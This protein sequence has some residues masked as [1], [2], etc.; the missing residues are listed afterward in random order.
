MVVELTRATRKRDI[1]N[2]RGLW[3][4]AMWIMPLMRKRVVATMWKKKTVWRMMANMV[5]INRG[6][7]S[8]MGAEQR[9]HM[10]KPSW[11]SL[12]RQSMW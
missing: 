9:E 7:V 10:V 6:C 5:G 4:V 11:T 1:R 8:G 2:S 3:L 12:S